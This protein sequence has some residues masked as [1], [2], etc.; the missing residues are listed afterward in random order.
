MQS[1]SASR[2]SR[3]LKKEIPVLLDRDDIQDV[4]P[5]LLEYPPKKILG[6]LY[7]AL[8]SPRKLVK[9]HAVTAVGLVAAELARKELEQGRIVMRRFMWT[10]NDESGGIGWGSPECMGEIMARHEQLALEFHRI[11]FSYMAPGSSGSDNFLEYLAL[12]RGAF[13][14]TARMAQVR[15]EMARKAWTRIESALEHET[16]PEILALICLY[17]RCTGEDRSLWAG[18]TPGNKV[19]DLYWDQKLQSIQ[20]ATLCRD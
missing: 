16:D 3:S 2:G 15:P 18:L 8:L 6:I 7:S 20:A 13:W 9:W 12:R 19:L 5:V 10:L 17:L 11:L 14:G 4:L 1:R